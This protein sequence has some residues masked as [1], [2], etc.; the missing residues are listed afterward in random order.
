MTISIFSQS[1]PVFWQIGKKDKSAAEFALGP[2]NNERFSRKFGNK[3]I[4]YEI[5]K[6]KPE[7]DFPFVLPGPAD[8]W[9]GNASHQIV[10]RFGIKELSGLCSAQLEL[11][12]VETQPSAPL[13][14]IIVNDFKKEI[15]A[16]SGNDTY[17]D[18]HKINPGN[19]STVI[20]I[21]GNVLKKGNN[22]VVIN[23]KGGSW[24]VFDHLSLSTA[25]PLQPDKT[26]EATNIVFATTKP[27]LIYGKNR[28]LR[29]PVSLQVANWGKTQA[30]DILVDG[31]MAEKVTLS[32]G[33]TTIETS[34]P[35]VKKETDVAIAL[36][37]KSKIIAQTTVKAA[38]VKPW[39]IYLVQHTHTDIGYTKP[40]TE[41]LA[42]HIRY[43]DYAVEYCELTDHYPDDAKFRWTCEAAW[44]VKE[45]LH[46]RPKVQVDKFIKYA[47][48]GRIEVAGM[49][50][51][52]SEIVDENSFKTFLEPVREFKNLGIPVKTAMQNDVNGI[53]WCLADYLP[54][55]GIKYF[56][57][58]ENG[59]RAL[60]PFDRATIYKWESPSGKQMY[61]YRSDHYHMGNFWGINKV[62]NYEAIAPAVFNYLES[63]DKKAYPFDA[64]SVQYS[65]YHTDNSPPSMLQCD[66]IQEWNNKYA[67]PKFKSAVIS[68]FMDYVTGKY[69]GKLPVYRVAY[70]DWWTDGFG[71]AARETAAAR[72]THADMITIQGLL[73]MAVLK[74]KTLPAH[75]PDKIRHVH[76]NLLFYD[77]HTYGSSE[78]IRDPMSD[79]SMVQWAEKASYVWEALKNAQIMYETSVG[80]LQ[81]DIQRG[82][83][84]T[85]TFYNTLNWS[86]SG[87]VELYIDHEIIPRNRNFKIV[88]E[89]GK[90]LKT[91]L[92]RSRNEGSYYAI[93]AD[94]LPSMG[95]K[96]YR[97]VVEKGNSQ[98]LPRT[99]LND[100]AIEN[101]YYCMIFDV[102][103]GSVKSLF[104][105]KLQLEMVD[106]G[107][108]WQLGA[109]V[110]ETLL[111]NR[112]QMERYTLTE[113]DRKGMT[114]VQVRAGVNGAIYQS[115]L[116]EGKSGCCDDGFG[117]KIEIRLFHHEKR[118]E[119]N[120]AL[121]K[122]PITAPDG[123]Y[124][125][126]PFKLDNAK[127]YFDVQGGVVSS[128]ENQLE[129]TASDWNTV[130]NFVTARNDKAQFIVGSNLIPL[131]QMGGICTGQYQRKKSYELPHVY[132]WVTNNYW[133]T[134]FRASQEGELRWSYYLASYDDIS[135]TTATRFGWSSRVPIYAR[136][137][138]EGKTNNLP[139][140]YSSFSFGRDNLLM[141]SATPSVD[142]GFVLI[143]VRELDGKST[144][145]QII[146]RSGKVLEFSIVNAIEEAMQTGLKE[147]N[148]AP[149][150]NKFIKLK[151]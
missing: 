129:G 13:L 37:L 125:A 49:F 148:F 8:G 138:P 45:Y 50:F 26:T 69:A 32:N 76:E 88:D 65:G 135:N 111:G 58:G 107:S 144:P 17:F 39:T 104:D 90:E 20:D 127:L 22:V 128:G 118:I 61:S 151:L 68:E 77:E 28:E 131:F 19:L 80:L 52:M 15:Q 147:T 134:N 143:N 93:Y 21:P 24:A 72:R 35:E 42:E 119:L 95:Y 102:Q 70:P 63:L 38:P 113:Y 149:F 7:T 5:G 103:T 110:Y 81:S 106:P 146:D 132:S 53:A 116:I 16:P 89:K 34:V 136:V 98:A 105:K 43:I 44:A 97:I 74:D 67:T 79:N 10:I 122:T 91:Q 4:V 120:Y 9:A 99:S 25:Y 96:T 6:S 23:S 36:S 117:V 33:I 124:V 115:V 101:D 126:F 73:S 46:N 139:A 112:R 83:Y 85:V 40:Q 27:G 47:K 123:I 41:I 100:N 92:L 54:D 94:D 14:E 133:T 48:E 109:L 82:E 142:K 121:R 87:M 2:Y 57:M 66:L 59:H 84:P 64:I 141:T 108:D 86:R 3:P 114:D 31:K 29:Q 140:S 150:E 30:V 55:L 18:L 75:V 1:M 62:D 12:Y 137:M 145:L 78:S 56:T 11:N 71:S 130:Q 51:N 60:I